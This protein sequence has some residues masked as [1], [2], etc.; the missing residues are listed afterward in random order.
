ML[1]CLFLFYLLVEKSQPIIYNVRVDVNGTNEP[2]CII[3]L[4]SCHTFGYVLNSLSSGNYSGNQF[5][6]VISYS[7]LVKVEDDLP[8]IDS[9]NMELIGVGKPT[10]YMN[11]LD[12]TWAKSDIFSTDNLILHNFTFLDFQS[13]RIVKF[14]N[15]NLIYSGS[16]FADNIETIMFSGRLLHSN[17]QTIDRSSFSLSNVSNVVINDCRFHSFDVVDSVFDIELNGSTVSIVKSTFEE[18]TGSI[19]EISR[20]KTSASTSNS[21][22]AMIEIVNSSFTNNVVSEKGYLIT[23]NW[24]MEDAALYTDYLLVVNS[25]FSEKILRIMYKT[26]KSSIL[27]IVCTTGD[28]YC[29]DAVTVMLLNDTFSNNLGTGLSLYGIP[30]NL[31]SLNFTNNTGL[32]AAGVSIQSQY[33]IEMQD[34]FFINNTAI[35]GGVIFIQSNGGCPNLVFKTNASVDIHFSENSGIPNL[36]LDDTK[37]AK[38]PNIQTLDMTEIVTGPSSLKLNKGKKSIIIFP[39][40][41]MVFPVIVLTV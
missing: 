14:T 1:L 15:S 8:D 34:V 28:W 27:N 33:I 5:S 19:L 17:K 40:Q 39:G 18:I 22:Y 6:V 29:E 31:S 32:F 25:I 12:L 36:Y 24:Q 21:N 23:F 37:C 30:A 11:G 10:L 13:T 38:A 26:Y 35:F 41:Q 9:T 3:G 16:V 4:G 2:G 20:R 7:H